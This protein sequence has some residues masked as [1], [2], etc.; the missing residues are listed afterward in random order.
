MK[1]VESID[2][3]G[4]PSNVPG[5]SEWK[6]GGV[7][8]IHSQIN[9]KL[10][11]MPSPSMQPP[12]LPPQKD[13]GGTAPHTMPQPSPPIGTAVISANSRLDGSQTRSKM[14]LN[15]ANSSSS[16]PMDADKA[17]HILDLKGY[18][19]ASCILEVSGACIILNQVAG[20]LPAAYQ[21]IN[22]TTTKTQDLLNHHLD[23][24]NAATQ[25]L[26]STQTLASALL[27]CLEEGAVDGIHV[28]RTMSPHKLQ[29]VVNKTDNI[30][31]DTKSKVIRHITQAILPKY[32]LNPNTMSNRVKVKVDSLFSTY[33]THEK[34]LQHTGE[35]VGDQ[36]NTPG[37]TT[38]QLY[39]PAQGPDENTPCEAVNIWDQ[40]VSDFPFFSHHHR[41][42]CTQPNIA[43]IV[44]ATPLGPC[45]AQTTWFQSPDDIPID[46]VLFQEDREY[47]QAQ[48]ALST[49]SQQSLPSPPASAI[50][51]VKYFA[52][53][54]TPTPSTPKPLLTVQAFQKAVHIVPQKKT[55][56][57]AMIEIAMYVQFTYFVAYAYSSSVQK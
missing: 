11:T 23:C 15:H 9:D 42:L 20:L 57:D 49:P 53:P 44:V 3:A 51:G 22:A 28:S 38:L 2:K 24:F 25:W 34:H 18:L 5:E 47:A 19:S 36:E 37:T 7:L 29:K 46:P 4:D 17:Q 54:E 35:G 52:A 10:K 31:K 41:H 33:K 27:H 13:P 30:P 14:T 32:D 16:P 39:V 50:P 56:S 8:N 12:R 6:E 26:E 40:I 43:P 21:V 55:V 45:G 1:T 48:A